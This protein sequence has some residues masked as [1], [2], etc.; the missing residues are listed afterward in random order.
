MYAGPSALVLRLL[1]LVFADP[2]TAV[3]TTLWTPYYAHFIATLAL[4][5]PP[6]DWPS[7]L[8]Y[9]MSIPFHGYI[10]FP[11]E[12]GM[13]FGLNKCVCWKLYNPNC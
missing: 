10:S 6:S 3:N 12:N 8:Q 4:L 11:L 1:V 13:S 2:S 7:I 9:V 5:L